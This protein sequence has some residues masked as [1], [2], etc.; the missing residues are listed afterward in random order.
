MANGTPN[1]PLGHAALIGGVTK[2]VSVEE[3]QKQLWGIQFPTGGK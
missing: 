1:N 2:E 3:L